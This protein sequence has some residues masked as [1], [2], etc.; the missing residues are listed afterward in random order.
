MEPGHLGEIM[1]AQGRAQPLQDQACAGVKQ[2]Q[3]VGHRKATTGL[4]AAEL[5]KVLLQLGGIGH[6]ET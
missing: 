2:G 6:G 4:L 5:P 1:G 3:E